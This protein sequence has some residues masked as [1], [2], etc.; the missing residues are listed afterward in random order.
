MKHLALAV[1]A[2]ALLANAP[3]APVNGDHVQTARTLLE[4]ELI[5]YSGTKL[6]GMYV[7]Q[8]TSSLY[9]D[10][11]SICGE[12]NGP[13]RAGGMTGWKRVAIMLSNKHNHR[14]VNSEFSDVIDLCGYSKDAPPEDAA[15]TAALQPVAIQS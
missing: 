6:R 9:G 7:S 12:A 13:N 15:L 14:G 8:R 1:S 4:N 11:L 5:D 10:A 2:L 3:A